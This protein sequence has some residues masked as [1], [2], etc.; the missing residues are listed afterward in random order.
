MRK[1]SI[2]KKLVSA[3]HDYRLYTV[4]ATALRTSAEGHEE[5]GNFA[6]HD[7]F[8][9]L[10]GKNE[11]WVDAKL[12]EREGLFYQVNALARLVREARGE[13]KDKAYEAALQIE[14]TLREQLTGIKYRD[15]KPHRQVPPELYVD[16]YAEVPDEV[17][18]IEV[19]RIDGHLARCY[20]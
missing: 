4:D 7:E 10:I 16:A 6:T 19:W 14:R 8:P 18:R 11:I 3:H 5:F 1:P 12:L 20:Y 2:H 13:S 17:E 9:H 15:G